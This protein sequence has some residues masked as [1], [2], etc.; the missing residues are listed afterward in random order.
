[1]Q[2]QTYDVTSQL[3]QGENCLGVILGNG[4][5]CGN[6]QL[7][8]RQL[9]PIYGAQPYFLLQLEVELA[10]GTRQIITTDSTWKGTANGPLRF[11]GLYEGETYDA[12]IEIP[13]WDT[14][15]FKPT[16]WQAVTVATPKVGPLIW[17]RNEPIRPDEEVKT[18]TVSQPKPGDFVFDLGQ[19]MAGWPRLHLHEP[20]GTQITLQMNEVIKIDGTVY[21][22]DLH[23]GH[24]STGDRQIIRYTCKGGDE[25]YEPHFTYMGFRYVE[26]TGLTEPQPDAD[27]V[28][29]CVI[30]SSATPCGDFTCSNNLVNK[31]AENIEWSQR[32]NMMGIPT[33]C[34]Q[35]D[36]RNGATGDMEF[37]C[38][39]AVYNYDMAAFCNKWLVDL[40]DDSQLPG[41]WF[42]DQAPYY[43]PGEG[44]NVGWSDAGIIVPYNMYRT[45][46]DTR[47]IRDHYAEMQHFLAWIKSNSSNLLHIN[48]VGNGDLLNLEGGGA[49][50][51]VIGTAY[52]AYDYRL[53]AEM[54]TA[55]GK[56][57]DSAA[58][59]KQ[60]D[61]ITAAFQKAFIN[62]DGKI[63]ESSQTGYALAFTMGLVPPEK[64]AKMADQFANELGT[65]HNFLNT[66]IMGTSRLLPGLH[67]AGMDD[68]AYVILLN[69]DYPS[70]LF[71]VK[72]GAT[73][74][75]ERWNSLMPN[76][77]F[78]DSTLNS[79]NH[80]S[81]GSVG[82]YL[83]GYVGGIQA[84]E[85]GY[86]KIRIAP[87]I[88]PDLEF[89]KAHYDSIAGTIS[90][91][92]KVD[93]GT[94]T[95]DVIIPANTTAIVCIPTVSAD[96]VTESGVAADK[97]DG[98]KFIKMEDKCA[99]Y[100]VESG[101]YQFQ[102]PRAETQ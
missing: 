62:D 20:A 86:K 87:V 58:Y 1:V 60:A 52:D 92:W 69:E 11:S 83:F 6:W 66:G 91:E 26:V 59:D 8:K 98:V 84:E 38:P 55:I 56:N 17:Q 42:A 99:V 82:E 65:R 85:P 54:A 51:P 49:S 80:Y 71:E 21:I 76:K 7:G 53:M 40:C 32:S 9:R 68:L 16:T 46:G 43:G 95:M 94:L 45:Y 29:G 70:W 75:W 5:Y 73:T 102:T 2:Y 88:Q 15:D 78:A 100:E 72:A 12:R 27:V 64:K 57:D 39:T 97:A 90:S 44:P 14:A 34:C 35:R 24:L 23:T 37:Y 41:G 67:E 81:Q 89:A 31:L 74:T 47:V 28:T 36:D 19:N 4:W 25:I 18:V 48:N 61:L 10:D 33:D 22:D 63:K 79:F 50:K 77:G 93:S 96:N 13:G 30:H 101:K 3:K